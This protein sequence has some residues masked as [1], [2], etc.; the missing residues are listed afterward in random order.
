ML[1]DEL[2]KDSVV[3]VILRN[4]VFAVN[5]LEF[6]SL[7]KWVLLKTEQVQDAAQSLENKPRLFKNH[8]DKRKTLLHCILTRCYETINVKVPSSPSLDK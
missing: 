2:V 4:A 6:G 5:Y 1:T 7:F 8:K 3:G